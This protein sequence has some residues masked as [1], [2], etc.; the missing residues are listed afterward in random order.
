MPARRPSGRARRGAGDSGRGVRIEARAKLNLGLAVGPR[1]PDGF[2]ELATIFQSVSLADTLIARPRERGFTL[3]VRHEDA[4]LEGGRARGEAAVPRG[5]GNLVLR[6]ARL[7][8]ARTGLEA[9]AS[10]ELV[11]RIPAG[12]GLGGGSADAAA[13][14]AALAALH[15]IRLP[16]ARR[17][18]LAAEIGAD[19]PFA[20]VG[21]TALGLGRGERL[22]ALSLARPFRAL[23]AVPRWRI[24]T[25]R[26]YAQIDRSKY[27]LTGW[28][29]KLRFAQ[30][31]GR[32]SLTPERA[33]HLGNTF[34][35]VLGRKEAMFVSLRSRLEHAGARHCH[36]TGSGSA[37]FGVLAPRASLARALAAFVGNE[38]L[39]A[40]RSTRSAM[41]LRRL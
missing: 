25:G 9:G 21:G 36:L 26:A 35:S 17:L 16:R 13:T 32:K 2:H 39:F 20:S 28:G 33:L 29:A 19:V 31:M 10:F 30:S 37:V 6:A 3:R 1:R 4:A 40:A 14:I 22:R 12:A 34:E 23:I 8:A 27:G 38:A 11:K 41:I 24:T 5:A 15:R 18:A 7:F